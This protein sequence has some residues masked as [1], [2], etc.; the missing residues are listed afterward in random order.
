MLLTQGPSLQTAS[1]ELLDDAL[2]PPIA[3]AELA[4][5]SREVAVAGRRDDLCRLVRSSLRRMLG[6]D[7]C[8]VHLGDAAP[9]PA[10]GLDAGAPPVAMLPLA[11]GLGTIAVWRAAPLGAAD[12]LVLDVVGQQVALALQKLALAERLTGEHVVRDLLDAVGADD[13]ATAEERA[14]A[15]GHDLAP[16]H[17]VALVEPLGAPGPAWAD[18]AARVEARL[19]GAV[20]GALCDSDGER[21]RA[22]VPVADADALGRLDAELARAAADDA[23]VAGRSEPRAATADG[24][25]AL[26][27]AGC[28]MRVARAMAPAGGARRYGELGVYRYLAQLPADDVP[29]RRHAEAIAVL[30]AYDAKRRTDLLGTLERH[31]GDRG[32]LAATARALYIH[33]NTL[34]QRLDRIESLTGLTLAGED[35][36]SLELALKLARLRGEV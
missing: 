4:V 17:V 15:L 6:A 22:L 33:T 12:A 32:A 11:D 36:L 3:L 29:D 30:A 8:A 23:L 34:R 13:A 1:D 21:V 25:R 19:A 10:P 31:L 24:A 14:R 26:T 7:R 9:A 27:E 18:T 35:L 28:A 16:A 5:L 2:G 20:R